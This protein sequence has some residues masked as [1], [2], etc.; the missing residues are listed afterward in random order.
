M[1]LDN[2]ID[3]STV[4]AGDIFNSSSSLMR[5]VG[6]QVKEGSGRQQSLNKLKCY[7]EWNIYKGRKI[8]VTEIYSNPK[9]LIDGRVKGGN[10][11][12]GS[13]MQSLILNFLIQEW[14]E[15]EL[16]YD[17]PED[18]TYFDINEVKSRYTFRGK[19]ELLKYTEMPIESINELKESLISSDRNSHQI[20]ELIQLIFYRTLN[21]S[22]SRLKEKGYIVV[23]KKYLIRLKGGYYHKEIEDQNIICFYQN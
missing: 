10:N 12:Y 19:T 6:I 5:V 18:Y 8:I 2:K 9:E 22:L 23:E 17:E 11:K 16:S 4:K 3:F 21:S 1:E 7:C 13:E 20:L 14:L 15:E